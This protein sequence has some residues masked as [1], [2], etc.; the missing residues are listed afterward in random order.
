MV[1]ILRRFCGVIDT[2]ESFSAVI[3][4]PRS[5]F[6]LNLSSNSTVEEQLSPQSKIVVMK[7]KLGFILCQIFFNLNF[8]AKRSVGTI[9]VYMETK[10][11]IYS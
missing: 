5:Q 6:V 10:K 1:S 7:K 4:T 2:L 3:L 11:F 9:F 8:L